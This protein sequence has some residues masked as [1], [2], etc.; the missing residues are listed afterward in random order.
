M[1]LVE[2]KDNIITD[3]LEKVLPKCMLPYAEYVILD[4][5]LPRVE[6][7]LKPVQRRILYS[8]FDQGMTPD[9]DF[10][11]SA[12]VVGDCLAKYHPHGDTSVYDAMVRLAQPFNMRAMLVEGHGN[13]GSIDGDGA[14]AMRYTEVKLQPLALEL[15]RD[16][17]KNTVDWDL[18]FDDSLKEPATLPGRYPNL[19][20]NGASGIAV[21]LATNIPPHNLAEVIDGACAVIDNPKIKLSDLMKII[22]GPDFP[23]GGYIISGDGL[24]KAYATGKGKI[25]VQS[26]MNVEQDNGKKSIVITE[27]PYQTN[28]AALLC[29]ISDLCDKEKDI[30][31]GIAEVCDE[32]DRKGMRAVIKL[33]KDADPD[34]IIAYLN[35]TTGLQ[36]TFG[37]NMVAIANG[38]PKQMGLIEILSYYVEYQRNIVLRR[39]KFDLDRAKE[40]AHIL[41][42]LIIAVSNID[43]VIK[44]IKNS[45]DTGAARQNLRSRFNLSEKQAQA[46]LDLRLARLTKLEV[47]NLKQ[48]LKELK[49]RIAELQAIADSKKLQMGLVKSEMLEIKKKYR[50]ERRSKIVG[51]VEEITVAKFDDVRPVEDFVVGLASNG[52]IRKIKANAFKRI[53]TETD[54]NKKELFDCFC[55]AT[56][57]QTVLA[58]TNFGNCYKIDME[59]LPESKGAFAAGVRFDQ[60][61][62][63]VGKEKPVAL[64]TLNDEGSMGEGRL[65]F[66]TKQGFVKLTS[67]NEYNLQKGL[68]QAIKLKDGDEVI[69]VK[70]ETEGKSLFFATKNGMCLYAEGEIPEQGR[71]AGGVKG[72]DVAVGDEL[73]YASQTE[74]DFNNEILVGTSNGLFKRVLLGTINKLARARKGVKIAETAAGER[75]AFVRLV[76]GG[77]KTE[78]A[79]IDQ[80]GTIYYSDSA[81]VP[82]ESRTTKGKTL[83]KIGACQP[84]KVFII[85]RQL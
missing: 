78:F 71:V 36:T 65:F 7:G 48:E 53:L 24:E 59:L 79:I 81:K 84:E 74:D 33:K 54:P 18:N 67:A 37:I 50:D 21:G 34:K 3:S 72:I 5:A 55:A 64:Y 46:I 40:R 44:I 17:D 60:M 75:I 16:I 39:T 9:K 23:T 47:N 61:F 27:M 1:D 42:G 19:L 41:E 77:E 13:F 70:R 68:Y 56:S 25:I 31:G 10:K 51:A 80:S 26:K 29:K 82:L 43:E 28:K 62:K 69:S 52:L 57:A 73:I 45:S 66:F 20:V 6:D 4:R 83:P 2:R 63:N 14:A 12:R 8:M 30:L 85:A 76:T 58:F 49:Q 32:S 22:K 35:K 38:K 11:K 15:L